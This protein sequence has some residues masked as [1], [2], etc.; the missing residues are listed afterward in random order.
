MAQ[1]GHPVKR[2][3]RVQMGPVGLRGLKSGQW[4]ELLPQEIKTLR[5]QAFGKKKRKKRPERSKPGD[6]APDPS[7]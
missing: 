1:L 6:Y 4:R 7:S 3:K 5:G 2:L